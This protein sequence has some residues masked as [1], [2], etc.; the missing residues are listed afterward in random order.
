MATRRRDWILA[1]LLLCATLWGVKQYLMPEYEVCPACQGSRTA[2]CGAPGCDRGRVPCDGLCL[3]RDA[4]GWTHLDVRGHS[5]DELW[6]RFYHDDGTWVAWSQAHIGQVIEKVD[7]RWVNKGTCP[8]CGG[9]G[10]KPC[11]SCH[12]RLACSKCGGA[13][14]FRRWFL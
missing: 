3:K 8:I 4:P 13:G 6:M 7:G 1:A 14:R 5:P 9:T 10:L 12:G 2:S 11:P